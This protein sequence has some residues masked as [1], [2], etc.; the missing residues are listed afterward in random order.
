MAELTTNARQP[1]S[2]LNSRRKRNRHSD[3]G[4]P[5]PVSPEMTEI[6]PAGS[7]DAA[8]E[9]EHRHAFAAAALSERLTL[10]C[11]QRARLW[12]YID[13]HRYVVCALE[14][15]GLAPMFIG[16]PGATIPPGGIAS[17]EG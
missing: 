7:D 17:K 14:V 6:G 9:Q 1:R 11:D 2:A 4:R 8:R 5:A 12:L 10:R 13:N 16:Q 3:P 15:S